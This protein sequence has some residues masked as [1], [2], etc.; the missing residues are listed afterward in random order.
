MYVC[1]YVCMQEHGWMREVWR[2]DSIPNRLGILIFRPQSRSQCANV[3]KNN[4]KATV[5]P[6]SRCREHER[7]LND[8]CLASSC[9][10]QPGA[11][12]R[13]VMSERSAPRSTAGLDTLN[14]DAQNNLA[15]DVELALQA[16]E[17]AAPL[18]SSLLMPGVERAG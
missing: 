3:Y 7:L 11:R 18:A 10:Y 13:R 5:P 2:H 15:D 17:G 8:D 9:V 6:S 16:T 14:P 12:K 4:L 1:M